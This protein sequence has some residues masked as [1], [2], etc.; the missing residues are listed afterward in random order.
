MAQ[1]VRF[2]VHRVCLVLIILFGTVGCDQA[3]KVVMRNSLPVTGPIGFL[4]GGIRLIYAENRGA[5]L[6]LGD[7]LSDG[8]RIFCFNF[9]VGFCLLILAVWLFRKKQIHPA[10]LIGMS[11]ILGGGIGNLIDRMTFGKV[12]DFLILNAGQWHTGIFNVADVAVSSGVLILIFFSLR[13][14]DNGKLPA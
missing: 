6:N 4:N 14:K 13:S 9:A 10:T 5:F 1:R 2:S 8:L 7:N 3:T 11:L 12:T